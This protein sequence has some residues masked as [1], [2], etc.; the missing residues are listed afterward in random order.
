MKKRV[1]E[2]TR[3]NFSSAMRSLALRATRLAR[4][5]L[6]L[7]RAAST[8]SSA[9]FPGRAVKVSHVLLPPNTPPSTLDALEAR[10]A[11]GEPF[12][13][14]AR[15][16]SKCPSAGAGGS[17]GWLGRGDTVAPFEDAAF[18]TPVGGLARA[19]SDF[20]HHLILVEE[21][22]AGPVEVVQAGVTDLKA[23]LDAPPPGL[24]LIDVREPDELERAAVGGFT[25]L[26]LSAF[27]EWSPT[28]GDVL[29]P[30]APTYVLCHA[31]VRSQRA[32]SWL[33]ANAGFKRVFNVAGGIDAWSRLIDPSCPRY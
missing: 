2:P 20:G 5:R 10:A 7:A 8:G 21:E 26:P 3:H 28:V 29:D 32:A 13:D 18:A 27:G 31:G 15:E 24:Q 23:A 17:L 19:E 25:N 9:D 4:P 11:S 14:L 12:A 6:M 30:E 16:A 1:G 22:R 33:V